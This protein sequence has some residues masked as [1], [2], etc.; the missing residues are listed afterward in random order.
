MAIYEAYKADE[1]AAKNGKV[2]LRKEQREAV[3]QARAVFAKQPF[4][5]EN[6]CRKF[7]WNAKMRF[8]KT[9]CA[10]QLAK[11]MDAKKTLIVT[12]RPVV[13]KGWHEDFDK[14]FEKDSHYE[15][16]TRFEDEEVGSFDDLE[17]F[18]KKTGN[19]Y[20][21]FISMQY[22]R[23]SN[24]V[25]DEGKI[26][27]LKAK[28]LSNHWDLVVVDEAHEGTQTLLGSRVIEHLSKPG[29]CV[30][31]LSGTPFNLYDD[32]KDGEIF[33]WDYIAEQK[34][35]RNWEAEGNL[36]PNPYA[37][38][39]TMKIYTYDLGSLVKGAGEGK[40]NGMF[41]FS[42]FFRTWTGNAKRDGA[43]M[44]AGGKGKFIHEKS[45]KEFLDLL[46]KKDD[47]SNYPFSTDEYRKNF[48]HTLWVVPGVA[49]AKALKDL[50]CSHNVFKHFT[51]INVA[52][53]TD[54]DVEDE[55][56]LTRVHNAIGADPE[57]KYTITISC[58]RL[59]TGVTVPPWTAVFYPKIG[60]RTTIIS[61]GGAETQSFSTGLTGFTGFVFAVA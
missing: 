14:I 34:A 2:E 12:H 10:M 4:T 19:H 56:A 8:G 25:K 61:R 36:P 27:L 7:L 39:P 29:T 23:L 41:M 40:V 35:K 47:K 48:K 26:N 1:T 31:H 9:L 59:T 50:L 49:A 6:P 13:D 38:L 5:A 30:L 43:V 54:E 46:C 53:N 52:C 18:A 15:Y 3:K 28:I 11:E 20:V 16:G 42:E 22:L 37:D 17:V 33:T 21:F 45:V 32:F 24:L 58:G 55:N 44:P 51:V 57:K 60:S